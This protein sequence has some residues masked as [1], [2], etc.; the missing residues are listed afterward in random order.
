MS[1]QVIIGP[2]MVSAAINAVPGLTVPPQ[3]GA[4]AGVTLLLM[5]GCVVSASVTRWYLCERRREQ[6]PQVPSGRTLLSMD[7][8]WTCLHGRRVPTARPRSPRNSTPT[9]GH[10]RG[11]T[12]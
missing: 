12:S 4:T 7:S 2:A 1:T 9:P 10:I 6:A 11:W 3:F 8:A 5:V